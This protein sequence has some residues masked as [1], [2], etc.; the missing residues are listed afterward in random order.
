MLSHQ[1]P[2]TLLQESVPY[3][4]QMQSDE[5]SLE[6]PLQQFAI[7]A[8]LIDFNM[9]RMN[10]PDTIMEMR[11]IG[12]RGPIIGVS[13]GEEE[14]MKQFL[15]AGA[16][17]V[18]QKPAKTDQL[19]GMLLRGFEMVVREETRGQDDN[20][21]TKTRNNSTENS[22]GGSDDGTD[23]KSR[24]GSDR[25]DGMN[26][27]A[28]GESDDGT[29]NKSRRGSDDGTHNK[30]PGESDDG[31]HNKSPGE[32]DDGSN[33]KSPGESDDGMN[34]QA[35]ISENETARQ[36]HLAHLRRFVVESLAATAKT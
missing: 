2:R 24:R 28:R 30:S 13:G 17:E 22:Q 36:E 11:K 14:T 18:L 23:I 25:D 12:F 6:K 5:Q 7:D 33:N 9:P 3:P 35:P 27:Q 21:S 26:H 34:H 15:Q 8:V 31:T 16:D 20:S 19:V 10:G 32:S 29:D 1:T 4:Y